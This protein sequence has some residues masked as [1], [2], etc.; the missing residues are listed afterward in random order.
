MKLNTIA[1]IPSGSQS[2]EVTVYE[3]IDADGTGSNA[4]RN[5]K[6]YDNSQTV[7]LSDGANDIALNDLD[8]KWGSAYWMEVEVSSTDETTTASLET[9]ATLQSDAVEPIDISIPASTV[10]TSTPAPAV[11]PGGVTTSMPA[12]TV[13]TSTPTPGV[14]P[15]E[16]S[17]SIPAAV[18][19]VTTPEPAA[20]PGGVALAL[21]ASTVQ[22]ATPVPNVTQGIIIAA[23]ASTVQTSTP[24]PGVKPGEAAVPVP[25]ST[26]QTSTPSPE[27]A[28]PV[29]LAMPAS[30]VT[31]STPTPTV[32][33]DGVVVSVPASTVQISTPEPDVAPGEITVP[34]PV[35][36][37]GVTAVPPAAIGD[38]S[39]LVR[40]IERTLE[41]S[42]RRGRTL[43]WR[44]TVS[45]T[46]QDDQ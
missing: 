20:V 33:R 44:A 7:T 29:T 35:S 17:V 18:V 13:Q 36:T 5:G 1:N 26:V 39:A 31:V 43:T 21:P 2:I 28:A 10:Q 41:W 46:I 8:D 25:A 4:D 24:E 27:V 30:T 32:T 34:L 16:V 6:P 12:S 19:A 22:T 23:P 14:A 37:V 40:D 9:P 42:E 11:E 15:G 3:D 45:R 38:V